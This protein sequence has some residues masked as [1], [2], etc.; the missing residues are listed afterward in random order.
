MQQQTQSRAEQKGVLP[1]NVVVWLGQ[2]SLKTRHFSDS[3]PLSVSLFSLSLIISLSFCSR[4]LPRI[5]KSQINSCSSLR[6]FPREEKKKLIHHLSAEKQSDERAHLTSLIHSI[7]WLFKMFW[8][9]NRSTERTNTLEHAWLNVIM[10]TCV[11]K[12]DD[13]YE[14]GFY[15]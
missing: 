13:V 4:H 5:T 1:K 2:T 11:G 10:S 6:K 15:Y 8:E 12:Y 14:R 7:E 3:L 9:E